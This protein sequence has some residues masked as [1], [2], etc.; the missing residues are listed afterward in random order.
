MSFTETITA[1]L[2]VYDGARFRSEMD[3]AGA[4]VRRVGTEAKAASAGLKTMSASAVGVLRNVGSIGK[5]LTSFGRSW[6]THISLPL[7][8]IAAIAGHMA[9]N[10]D[11]SMTRIQTQTGA[12][13]HEVAYLRGQVLEL[14][15]SLPQGPQELAEGLYHIESIGI[16][17]ARALQVLRIAAEGAAV[18][19]ANLEATASALGG[20]WLTNIRGAGNLRH[21]MALL[22][23]TV[24][25]GNMRMEDLVHS[26]GVGVLPSAKLAGLGIEDVTSALA[27]LTDENMQGSSAMAQFSTALHFLYAPTRK[28]REALASIG[29]EAESLALDMHKP[30][31]LLV[32]LT[33]LHDHLRR[34][35]AVQ[36]ERVLGEI[37]PGGR[38][39]VLLI[40]LNQLER[41]DMKYRQIARTTQA[42]PADVARTKRT[43]QYRFRVAVSRL[44]VAGINLGAAILPAA[45][46]LIEK[47]AKVVEGL[48][49][50]FDKLSPSERSFVL[51]LA[52]VAIVAG[53]VI[54]VIGFLM[55]G[56]GA[57]ATIA[58]GLVVVID[59]VGAALLFVA[60]NP[61]I[62]IIAAV[63][64]LVVALVEAYRHV[65]WFRDAVDAVFGAIVTGAKW[66]GNAFMAFI[67]FLIDHWKLFLLVFGGPILFVVVMTI[68]H[69]WRQ[70]SS[71]FFAVIN[72]LKAH[73]IIIADI[74]TGGAASAVR[75]IVDHWGLIS[76]GFSK[77]ISGL[78]H[79][80]SV[81]FGAVRTAIVV[82]VNWIIDR[83]N[84]VINAYN[85]VAGSIPILG[86]DLK[87]ETIGHLGGSGGGMPVNPIGLTKPVTRANDPTADPSGR[88]MDI[89]PRRVK[90]F[91]KGLKIAHGAALAGTHGTIDNHVYLDG[92][93]I[94]R[95]LSRRTADDKARRSG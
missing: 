14:A 78:A 18:G 9:M 45:I 67:N 55:R 68:I 11:A 22:N 63:V 81:V 3:R 90:G 21:V 13:A 86:G 59:G 84:E 20:A 27:V 60:A 31:G 91:G 24:G 61:V 34:L 83:I 29:L 8:G 39:R 71:A 50:A 43:P 66:V 1:W 37:L 93:K 19:G 53:P 54:T 7:L 12:S 46:P 42:F 44:Q 28:A 41:L 56:I 88:P 51:T 33:D 52:A 62:L 35:S 15:K 48:V 58:E 23:A 85:S 49:N 25:A 2:K 64:A 92:S 70:I 77:A 95:V 6:T 57:L 79:I 75:F 40:L 10:F 89:A 4:S 80:F 36:Q 30:R 72:F 87:V 16:R 26:L 38:G 32:A 73:W 76:S 47:L 65:G 69:F 17:G 82:A 5:R 94:A 74:I